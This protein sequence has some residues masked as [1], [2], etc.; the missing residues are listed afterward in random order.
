MSHAIFIMNQ[1]VFKNVA[2]NIRKAATLD[3]A[4]KLT[5]EFVEFVMEFDE[6][7]AA[8][9]LDH[10]PEAGAAAYRV[11]KALY[12]GGT[13]L[14]KD[15]ELGV[16]CM[17]R[18]AYAGCEEAILDVFRGSMAAAEILK[19]RKQNGVKATA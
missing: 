16:D 6:G 10:N 18:G 19:R 4:T 5:K 3:E 15:V 8:H 14:G 2:E 9:A 7:L 17:Q 1:N 13:V 12:Y 11:G